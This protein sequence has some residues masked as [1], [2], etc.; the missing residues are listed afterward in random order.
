MAFPIST[1]QVAAILGVTEPR[2]NDLIRR[3]KIDPAPVVA[4][5]RSW[6]AQQIL[7][8]AAYL[9]MVVDDVASAL[10]ALGAGEGA[11]S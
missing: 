5:R 7:Q 9:G 2:L 6:S 10:A 1:G 3:R 11:A 8:A 4:G